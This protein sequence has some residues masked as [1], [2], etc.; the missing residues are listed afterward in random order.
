[1]EDDVQWLDPTQQA[2]WRALI[3]GTKRLIAHLDTDLKAEGLNNDDYGVLVALSEA[4][5]ERLRMSDLAESVVESRSRLSHHIGRMERQGLVR[6]VAC[7]EDRRGSWAELT[8]TGRAAIERLAPH[9]VSSVRR[10]FLDH[11]TPQELA[12]VAA[13]FSRVEGLGRQCRGDTDAD[14]PSEVP[15]NADG[16]TCPGSDHP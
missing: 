11:A 8:D 1:M 13:V 16:D 4:E 5:G 10:W 2:A 7:P 3:V 12:V 9:H 15:T 6:R 14:C